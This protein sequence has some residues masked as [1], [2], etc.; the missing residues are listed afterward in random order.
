MKNSL[1]SFLTVII[2]PY[3]SLLS[4]SFPYLIQIFSMEML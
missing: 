2:N 3:E 4:P 1:A